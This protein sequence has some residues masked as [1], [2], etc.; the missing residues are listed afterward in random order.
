VSSVVFLAILGLVCL[1]YSATFSRCRINGT[2]LPW[3]MAPYKL[4]RSGRERAHEIVFFWMAILYL[5]GSVVK[6]YFVIR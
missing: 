4:L 5:G 6:L 2:P 3:W 1:L